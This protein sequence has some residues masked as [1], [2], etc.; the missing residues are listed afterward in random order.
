M[1]DN[2]IALN[3]LYLSYIELEI[4]FTDQLKIETIKDKNNINRI[5]KNLKVNFENCTNI[6]KYLIIHKDMN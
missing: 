4:K 2:L 3:R 5:F 1:C 6:Q